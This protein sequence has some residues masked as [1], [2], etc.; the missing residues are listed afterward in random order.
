MLNRDWR[1]CAAAGLAVVAGALSCVTVASAAPGDL[2][3]SYGQNGA[4]VV[5]FGSAAAV[6]ALT[7][8]GDGKV[9]GVGTQYNS[10]AVGTVAAMRLTTQGG[11]IP[12]MARRARPRSGHP[13]L[14]RMPRP[15]R[16]RTTASW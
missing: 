1:P 12:P 7:V 14:T 16:S 6:S 13:R 2:D 11:S 8:Q 4:A 5:D 3:T 9:I 15:P 10:S